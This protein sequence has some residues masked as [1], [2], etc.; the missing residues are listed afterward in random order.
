MEDPRT[1]LKGMS[2]DELER[3][4]TA[5]GK[6]K[7]RTKQLL[8]WI[9]AKGVSDFEAMTDLSKTFREEL[10]RIARISAVEEV[11]RQTSTDGTTKFLFQLE[12]GRRIESVLIREGGQKTSER[13]KTSRRRRTVCL[14]S[15]VGCA[16]GC[17]FC[18]TGR[19]GFIR[20]L[21][22][23][24][25]VD[26]LIAVRRSEEHVTNVVLMGMGEPL[27]NYDNVLKAA[28]L[29]NL[30]MGI[31]L[32]M[33]KITLSTAGIVPGIERLARERLHIGLAISLNA[34]DDRT[35][36]R[37][38]PINRR[39]PLDKL[40]SAAR[41][42]SRTTRRRITFEYIL[43]DGVNDSTQD[44]ARLIH[45]LREIPCKINLIPLNPIP[46]SPLRRPSPERIEAFRD[47]LLSH[48]FTAIVRE[49]KGRNI[50]AACGQLCTVC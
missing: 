32:G 37:L 24:E 39:Y 36:T 25:I 15:Q 49:S 8:S 7:Y 11:E 20:D 33:R 1:D 9:Y 38:M 4:I 27:L 44:A 46:K 2:P 41:R 5:L 48:H 23:A 19:M 10:T 31:A 43:I 29:M 17:T 35:R 13:Q 28:R 6:E 18:A 50:A 42:F 14:S 47:F 40:L 3:F 30:E 45:L 12:D 21:T 16:L 22:A 34:T 26:Q